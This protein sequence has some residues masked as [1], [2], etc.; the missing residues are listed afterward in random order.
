M[1]ENRKDRTLKNRILVLACLFLLLPACRQQSNSTK[2]DNQQ[3]HEYHVDAAAPDQ[4]AATTSGERSIKDLINQ[5]G[6]TPNATLVL[7]HTGPEN[8]TTYSLTTSVTVPLNVKVKIEQGALVD[9]ANDATFT[10]NSLFEAGLYQVFGGDG[11]VSFEGV[12]YPEWFAGRPDG[13]KNFTSAIQTCLNNPNTTV[14]FSNTSSNYV[15]DLQLVVHQSN[16]TIIGHG[17]TLQG[18][19][20]EAEGIYQAMFYVSGTSGFNPDPQAD[21]VT[22]I[23]ILGLM[24]RNFSIGFFN[25][26][27]CTVRDV[28]L[29]ES[30]GPNISAGSA[31]PGWRTPA[32]LHF[33]NIYCSGRTTLPD[34]PTPNAHCRA[35]ITGAE[36][37]SF[38]NCVFKNAIQATSADLADGVDLEPNNNTTNNNI[39]FVNCKFL[40]NDDFGIDVN[41][42]GTYNSGATGCEISG[43]DVGVYLRS[44]AGENFS[45]QDCHIHNNNLYGIYTTSPRTR[46]VNNRLENNREE[47]YL[48]RRTLVGDGTDNLGAA[49]KAGHTGFFTEPEAYYVGR[50]VYNTTDKSYALITAKDSDD[51]LSINADL[52]EIGEGFEI[53]TSADYSTVMGNVL[54]GNN[55]GSDAHD[56]IKCET[57]FCLISGNIIDYMQMYGIST[58]AYTSRCLI[59][60]NIV[61]NSYHPSYSH[62]LLSGSHHTLDG[63]VISSTLG[64]A[65]AKGIH[66]TGTHQKVLNNSCEGCQLDNGSQY[67]E[68]SNWSSCV[69]MAQ[70]NWDASL[71]HA[72][73]FAPAEDVSSSRPSAAVTSANWRLPRLLVLRKSSLLLP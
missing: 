37:V 19:L 41:G 47:I 56:G 60:G 43:N 12:K 15:V 44:D 72:L 13:K 63:N 61:R 69:E 5:I 71:G 49:N 28:R 2:P 25:A 26:T 34:E 57:S 3:R 40:D 24:G 27:D 30:I 45:I 67:V 62:I 14:V 10:I 7:A 22:N 35:A 73:N 16:T 65:G 52:M 8:T 50:Y 58:G 46:I 1:G 29:T 66:V 38:I 21:P 33:E 68:L 54:Y 17:A 55:D 51:V 20:T 31:S 59:S 4:G 32:R 18:V 53:H 48:L 9:I 23:R 39:W 70:N 11:T 64:P 6:D 42:S 36:D